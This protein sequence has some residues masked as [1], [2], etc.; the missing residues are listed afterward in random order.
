M[1]SKLKYLLVIPFVALML[2]AL[3]WGAANVLSHQVTRY[4]DA[5]LDQQSI[6]T[7]A[8]WQQAVDLMEWV[9]TLNPYRPEYL[10]F[11]GR[12][13]IWRLYIA[14][15]PIQSYE[16]HQEF[17]NIGL[18]YLR[19]AVEKRPVWPL[20]WAFIV[21]FKSLG[22]QLDE[23]YWAVWKRA[24]ELGRWDSTVQAKLLE[25]ALIHW[26]AFDAEHKQGAVEVF[27][28]MLGRPASERT[29]LRMADAFGALPLFCD[30]TPK[31]KVTVHMASGCA[32]I[33]FEKDEPEVLPQSADGVV[34]QSANVGNDQND[35]SSA[36]G[37]NSE[38]SEGSLLLI[39]P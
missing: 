29:A 11:M 4:E 37:K 5:W 19:S 25:S 17:I 27:W 12:L 30:I 2:W 13:Y 8:Q 21:E 6:E 23:E 1:M 7:L 35:A 14:D 3:S 34:S 15:A 31:D 32:D 16:E 39:K 10:E 22:A 24:R 9:L 20:T 26:E 33:E 38:N 28:D 18:T 36:G